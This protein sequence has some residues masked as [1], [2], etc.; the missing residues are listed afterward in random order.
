MGLKLFKNLIF[1]QEKKDVEKRRR[2][3]Q[4]QIAL[5]RSSTSLDPKLRGDLLTALRDRLRLVEGSR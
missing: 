5:V 3:L 4:L 2:N 1:R